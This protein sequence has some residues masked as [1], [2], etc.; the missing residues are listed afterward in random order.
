MKYLAIISS[1]FFIAS[2]N[3]KPSLCD[4]YENYYD[5]KKG[6][7]DTCW[8]EKFLTNPGGLDRNKRGFK[9]DEYYEA[10]DKLSEKVIFQYLDKEDRD[11]REKCMDL[12]DDDEVRNSKC[13]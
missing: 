9:G 6:K 3:D 11:I 4:C 5:I 13:K 1:L 12:Y 10:F 8:T 2:C 7:Y